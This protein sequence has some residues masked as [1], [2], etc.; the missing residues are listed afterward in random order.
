MSNLAVV[1]GAGSGV[2]RAIVLMLAQRGWD[3]ALIGRRRTTLDEVIAKAGKTTGRLLPFECDVADE[4]QTVAMA[5]AVKT[6]LGAPS[7]LVNNAGL[8][9]PKRSLKELSIADFR[10]M[11]EVNLVGA[12]VCVHQFLPMMRQI[13]VGTI[14][15]IVS[16]SALNASAKAGGGYSSSKAGLRGLNQSINAEERGNGIRACAIFPGDIDTPF[17]E[18]RPAPPNASQRAAML[19]PE[20]IAQCAILAIEMPARAMIEE[21]LIKPR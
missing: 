7:V 15:N 6:Q 14:I 16:D 13:G 21:L 10:R 2:G 5:Q 12:F 3:V 11:I 20:D 18:Q 1:T 19:Q 17:L 4:K 8:N 9:I